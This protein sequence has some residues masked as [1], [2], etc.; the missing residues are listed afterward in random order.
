LSVPA[1]Q[2]G[3]PP[4]P[5]ASGTIVGFPLGRYGSHA[6]RVLGYANPTDGQRYGD[7]MLGVGSRSGDSGGGVFCGGYLVGL[8]WGTRSDGTA[9]SMAI[10]VPAIAD[11]LRR[12]RM[13]I[14]RP[15]VPVPE[16]WDGLEPCPPCESSGC[17]GPGCGVGHTAPGSATV[18]AASPARTEGAPPATSELAEIRSEL[19]EL[20]K[21]IAQIERGPQGEPGPRGDQGPQGEPGESA[22]IDYQAVAAQVAPLLG[23]MY[24]QPVD[25]A[26]NPVGQPVAKRLGDTVNLHSYL[27]ERPK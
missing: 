7:L 24:F 20:R 11:F 8:L 13:K 14:E 27:V 23:A 6:G 22:A 26:G 4:R 25:R 2:L 17:A 10:A 19:S 12:V 21:L 9:G 3:S 15:P 18:Q 16:T 1:A 5:G